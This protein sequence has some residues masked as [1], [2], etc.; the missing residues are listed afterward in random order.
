MNHPFRSLILPSLLYAVA[1]VLYTSPGATAQEGSQAF[2]LQAAI[3]EAAPGATITVPSGIYL[4]PVVIDKSLRLV[5]EGMPVLQGDGEG[6]VV[7]ITA[8]GASLEGFVV[9]GSGTSLDREDAAVR[10]SADHVTVA[11]NQ[12]EEALFG[13]Y[14]ESAPFGVIRGNTIQGMDLPES[15]RGD[16]LKIFYSA[17]TLV[18]G[19]S[20]RETRDSVFWFSP[21]TEV[22]DNVM[23]NGR[24]GMHFMSTDDHLIENNVLRGNSVGIYLMYGSHYTVRNNLMADNRGPSGY[25]LGLKETNEALIEGNRIVNNRVGLYSD[26]S[27][28]RPDANVEFRTNLFAFNEIGLLLLPNVKRN[29]YSGNIF[30]ENSDQVSISGG[31]KL[32]ENEW[33]EA[34]VG[35]YWSDYRGYDADGDSIGDLP[36]DSHSLY[37]NMTAKYPELRM[38]Q[39]GPAADAIDLAARAFPIFEPRP[40]VADPHPLTRAP[41]LPPVPG[42]A[43]P[44]VVQNLAAS[45]ALIG[46]A[47]CVL[48]FGMR[49][50]VPRVNRE[51]S[52]QSSG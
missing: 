40:I 43:Q 2:D 36:Y 10:V 49:S 5:G 1:L 35:N 11:D 6:D 37:E 7:N 44:P 14:Y 42:L 41:A 28:L 51:R 4:G 3:A 8:P 29:V 26:A 13:I 27:P 15:R 33:S 20:L 18:K 46:L 38:F 12:I 32:A 30:L 31:G 22:S 9:R 25:G 45:L 39:G 50:F 24:Y 34:G 47:A 16:G 48:A 52:S 21:R 23:E 19:N 17:D